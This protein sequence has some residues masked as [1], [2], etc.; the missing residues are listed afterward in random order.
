MGNGKKRAGKVRLL[1]GERRNNTPLL[2]KLVEVLD[3]N[4]PPLVVGGGGGGMVTLGEY[5]GGPERVTLLE[6]LASHVFGTIRPDGWLSS[7]LATAWSAGLLCTREEFLHIWAQ[8]QGSAHEDWEIDETF[9]A[10]RDSRFFAD[11]PEIMAPELRVI[12]DAVLHVADQVLAQATPERVA[13]AQRRQ[14]S[15]PRRGHTDAG[16]DAGGGSS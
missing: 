16:P 7:Y 10:I 8:Q 9:A 11:R 12:A 13:E 3:I 2:L 4:V 5:L 1:V 6:F 15:T 14:Q